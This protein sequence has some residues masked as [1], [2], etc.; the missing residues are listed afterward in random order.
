[1]VGRDGGK[2]VGVQWPAGMEVALRWQGRGAVARRDGG[3][4]P[5][6]GAVQHLAARG[7]PC[8]AV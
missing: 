5:S 6:P 1:M 8:P 2:R 7:Q 3:G 4:G